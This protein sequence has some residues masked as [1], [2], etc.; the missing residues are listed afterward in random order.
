MLEDLT[1]KPEPLTARGRK[2]RRALLDAAKTVFSRDGFA[3]ARV[4]DIAD[5]AGAAHGSFYRYFESKEEILIT[6]IREIEEILWHPGRETHQ[7]HADSVE[8]Q[9]DHVSHYEQINRTNLAYLQAYL[10]HKEMM[11]V[12]Q[13]VATLNPVV[14]E[15]RRVAMNRFSRRAANAIRTWQ[16]E[17]SVD[18]AIDPDYVAPALTGMVSNFAYQWCN[19]NL[20]YDLDSAAEQLSIVWANALGLPR[21]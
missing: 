5:E 19:C 20:N 6:L 12:W 9:P 17:G 8:R 15:F 11:L 13:E 21:S 7:K 18:P 16:E 14:E 10:N 4:T 3:G 2:T 1:E